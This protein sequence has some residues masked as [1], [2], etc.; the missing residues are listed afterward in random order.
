MSLEPARDELAERFSITK[1]GS[2]NTNDL[3]IPRLNL[4]CNERSF[5][6]TG[7]KAPSD[8]STHIRESDTFTRFKNGLRSHF[9]G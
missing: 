8:I 5:N 9:I 6:Y 1:Y 3:Q 2:G 7:L 4:D